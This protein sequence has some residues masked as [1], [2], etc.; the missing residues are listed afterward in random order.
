MGWRM[1]RGLQLACE[2]CDFSAM[3]YERLPFALDA[4]GT[5][6]PLAT[7]G[8]VGA[9]AAGYW[10]DCLCGECRLPV[11]VAHRTAQPDEAAEVQRC[12]HCGAEPLTFDAALR[13][14][15]A[16]AH[17]RVWL[18][19]AVEREARARLEDA[20]ER[21]QALAQD[22]ERGDTTTLE[23][24]EELAQCVS[25]QVDGGDGRDGREGGGGGD[26]HQAAA[27]PLESTHTLTGLASLIENAAS[28]EQA[29]STLQTRL[30]TSEVY[31]RGLETCV[32]DESY[33]PG[34]P[35]PQCGTGHLVH[36]PLWQ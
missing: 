5:P 1:D 7:S 13:E 29:S 28:V 14:L 19:L 17:S 32:E 36:W 23:A 24:L 21:S 35:C 11:R 22:L 30:H 25:E 18:D 33:L 4:A 34:V 31:L 16:A 15:A 12:P 3:L 6:V 20:I 8:L 27:T 10:T 9:A 26:A 2:Q